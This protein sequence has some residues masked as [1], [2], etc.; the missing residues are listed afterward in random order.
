MTTYCQP[1]LPSVASGMLELV[2]RALCD[3]P[4]DKPVQREARARQMIHSTMGFEP[5]DGLEYMLS[6]LVYGHFHLIL[7]AMHDAML[8]QMDEIKTKT[9]TTIVSLDRTMLAFVK[10]IRHA[11]SRP[12]SPWAAAEL[13]RA[14]EAEPSPANREAEM[15]KWA[16]EWAQIPSPEPVAEDQA[17]PE[18]SPVP[19]ETSEPVE[20]R[21]V[22]AALANAPLANAPLANAPL[23]N[24]APAPVAAGARQVTQVTRQPVAGGSAPGNAAPPQ[25]ADGGNVAEHMAA[26]EEAMAAVAETLAEARAFDEARAKAK[27]ATGD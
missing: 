17:A 14:Q 2:A 24:A 10:E 12:L 23:A 27:A 1:L 6:T 3:L 4:G 25:D 20:A 26:F 18:A 9:K 15:Q 21:P 5:R 7:D 16:A 8:G 13:S 22:K 19:P 11:R